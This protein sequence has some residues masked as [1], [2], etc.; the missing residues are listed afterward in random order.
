MDGETSNELAQVLHFLLATKNR[1]PK[2][3]ASS[4]GTREVRNESRAV[5]GS[6]G[7]LLSVVFW[8]SPGEPP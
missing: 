7:G 6:A 1:L 2:Q 8:V 3:I 4:S 5:S